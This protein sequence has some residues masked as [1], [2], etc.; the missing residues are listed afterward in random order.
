VRGHR[1]V[2]RWAHGKERAVGSTGVE[3][4]DRREAGSGRADRG[5][6]G[7][8]THRGVGVERAAAAGAHLLQPVEIIGRMHAFELGSGRRSSGQ[9]APLRAYDVEPGEDGIKPGR[10][11]RMATARIVLCEQR[12]GHDEHHTARVP[13]RSLF[14]DDVDFTHA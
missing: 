14:G 10:A 1:V 11:L 13:V 6:E 7:T 4:V 3:G 2:A 5:L 9:I 8:L 12:V